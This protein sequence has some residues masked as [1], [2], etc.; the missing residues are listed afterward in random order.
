MPSLL[1]EMPFP[2]LGARQTVIIQGPAQESLLQSLSTKIT[3]NTK[4]TVAAPSFVLK[5]D[6]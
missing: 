4:P 1:P 3:A 5:E 2:R 6:F